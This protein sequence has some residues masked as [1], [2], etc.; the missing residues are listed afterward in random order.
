MPRLSRALLVGV[1]AL[2]VLAAA[3]WGLIHIPAVQDAT[4]G[5]AIE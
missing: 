2:V 1:A 5:R 3:F 4:L